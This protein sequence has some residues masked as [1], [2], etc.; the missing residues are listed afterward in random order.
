MPAAIIC[1]K[2]HALLAEPADLAR[3]ADLGACVACGAPTALKDLPLPEGPAKTPP[4]YEML[5]RLD[6]ATMAAVYRARHLAS[7]DLVALK[8]GLAGRDARKADHARVRREARLLASFDHPN[9][10]RLVDAGEHKGLPFLATEWLASGSLADRLAGG[11]LPMRAAVASLEGISRAAHH[12][13]LRRVAHLDLHPTNILF[14][15]GVARLIDFGL[16]GQLTGKTGEVRGRRLGGD[17]RYMAPEQAREEGVGPAADVH[18]LGAVLYQALTGRAPFRG[19]CLR[20]RLRRTRVV[21]PRASVLRPG[22]PTTL[23]EICGRC[24]RTD[25]ERRYP[26][27]EAL[28]DA[29]RG[30]LPSVTTK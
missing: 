7:G 5:Q 23:D 22:V 20:E 17:P 12:A 6:G 14:S 9:I 25:P 4:G 8:V 18:A 16:A 30:V 19:L 2:G 1:T 15:R 26:T 11:P 29:L 10:V 21:V 3:P 24:L 13:H 28:A 27:A